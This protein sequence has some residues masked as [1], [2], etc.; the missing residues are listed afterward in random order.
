[1][2]TRDKDQVVYYYDRSRRLEKASP[3][4]RFIKIGRAHV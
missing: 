4:A 2:E 1:M 3:N